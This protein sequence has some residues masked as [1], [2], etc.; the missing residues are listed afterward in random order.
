MLTKINIRLPDEYDENDW[1]TVK[2]II[3]ESTSLL[4]LTSCKNKQR[5]LTFTV[6]ELLPVETS[7]DLVKQ[8]VE[9]ANTVLQNGRLAELTEY[10]K[11]QGYVDRICASKAIQAMLKLSYINIMNFPEI[12]DCTFSK[13]DMLEYASF[14]SQ[15]PDYDLYDYI[16]VYER[17]NYNR[18]EP[19]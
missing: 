8:V 10:F 19:W 7:A 6:G 3:G 2:Y 16:D 9:A 11:A 18:A 13:N 5:D 12:L 4:V 17:V 15:N 1:I 14:V